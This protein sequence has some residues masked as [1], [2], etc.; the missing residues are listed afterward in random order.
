MSEHPIE[1]LMKT[2]MES[3]KEMVD[4]NTIVGDPVE[5]MDGTVIVPISRVA[6]GF[7]SGGGEYQ[8]KAEEKEQGGGK[9]PF[10]GGTGAG[11]SVQPVAFMVVGKEHIK[12]LPANSSGMVER[13]I[14]MAPQLIEDLQSSFKK[15]KNNMSKSETEH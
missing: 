11:V 9:L 5:T 6:L 13:L 8:K 15:V 2:T 7:A 1:A 4:V 10:A 12:L 14:E 3:L